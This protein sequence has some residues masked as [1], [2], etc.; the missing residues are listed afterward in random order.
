MIGIV[1]VSHSAALAAGVR[2]LA[3]QMTGG[4]V[5]IAVAGGSANDDDPIGTNPMLV[6]EAIRAVDQ[7]DDILVLMD[8]GSAIMSV[9]S[10]LDLLDDEQRERIFLCE[11]PVVEGAIAAAVQAAGGSD[12]ARIMAEARAGLQPKAD[13]LAPLLRIQPPTTHAGEPST[14]A[15]IAHA[16]H[17]VTL[18]IPNR[19]GLHARPAARLVDLAARFD[20][21]L[22]FTCHE[23]TA[24]GNSINQIATLGARQGD[25]LLVEAGG[26][27]AAALLRA[28]ETLAAANFG[29]VDRADAPSVPGPTPTSV[30]ALDGAFQGIPVVPGVAIGPA[31]VL[32]QALPEIEPWLV[33]DPAEEQARLAATLAA[34]AVDLEALAIT[35]QAQIAGDEAEII[36][37][38]LLIVRDPALVDAARMRI[39]QARIC[40]E[41]AWVAAVQATVNAYHAL[42][43]P[44]MRQRAVDVLSV[45]RRVLEQLTGTPTVARIDTRAVVVAHDLGPLDVAHFDADK[46]LGVVTAAGGVTG[47]AAILLRSLGIP[48]VMGLGAGTDAISDGVLVGLDGGHGLVWPE[49]SGVIQD[50]LTRRRQAWLDD[51]AR[52]LGQATAPARTQDGIRVRIAANIGSV[53]EARMAVQQ[54]ADEV[55]LFRTEFLFMAHAAAPPEDEQVAT[56]CAA[57]TALD[58]GRLV[59]RTL[60]A[61]ADKPIPYLPMIAEENPFLGQRGIRFSLAERDL[62]HVQLRALLRAAADY[63]IGIMFPMISTV[64]E[65]R[66]VRAR[67]DAARRSLEAEGRVAGSVEVGIMIE[68]PA[69]VLIAPAL[70]RMVD[71]FS[72]GT[73]DLMQYLLAADRNNPTVAPLVASVQPPL[74]HAIEAVVNAARKAGIWVGLCGELGGDPRLAPLLLGLGVNELSMSAASIPVVKATVR[75][76]SLDAASAL[77]ARVL[78]FNTAAEIDAALTKF[79]RQLLPES[80]E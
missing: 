68:T 71:F 79:H 42:D 43:D 57:A 58:G 32:T 22:R 65:V 66:E 8:L 33:D 56:Y 39:D 40:A 35:S 9:E 20:G 76:V 27:D 77:A 73:N 62:L 47:H 52:A 45:G 44:Y 25:Q 34:V 13:Q 50:E 16:S 54:G 69:A 23:R 64:D 75:A 26:P 41:A 10:V 72:I 28:V 31:L 59:V 74:L 67:L 46:V 7:G 63:R 11:A 3:A 14:T 48:T 18:T 36:D 24:A 15:P 53:A 70:A 19:L 55:G 51:Y 30:T 78:T 21:W 29:D 37:A 5:P 80:T 6:L 2:E 17:T 38:Q 12:I 49:P 4:R 61:G 60:D 1:I